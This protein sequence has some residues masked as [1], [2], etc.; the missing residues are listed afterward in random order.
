MSLAQ[1]D[2]VSATPSPLTVRAIAR[3][4]LP[5]VANAWLVT[6]AGPLLDAALGRAADPHRQ[7]AA[8]WLAFGVLM[9]A[10]SAC[11]VLPQVTAAT[12]ARGRTL[13]PVALAA[14][15]LAA[16][17]SVL[18]LA[19]A[20]TPLGTPVF[21]T[22][23]AA[24]G[25]AAALARDAL[26]PM[27]LVPPLVALRGVAAGASVRA[28]RTGALA[29]ATLV[30]VLALATLVVAVV[31]SHLRVDAIVAAWAMVFATAAEAAVVTLA[32]IA[33]RD[34]ADAARATE[35]H[36]GGHADA[37]GEEARGADAPADAARA[38]ARA[39][40]GPLA[41]ALGALARLALPLAAASLVWNATRPLVGALAGRLAEPELAQA[42]FGVVLPLLMTSC[43]PLWALLDAAIVL[44]G[45][46]ADVRR[47]A[48]YGA[49]AALA[50]AAAIALVAATPLSAL[51]LERG[52]ALSPS[53]AHVVAP[54]LVLL[55]LEPFALAARALAQGL[56]VR[57]GLA[58]VVLA[59]A[60][61][62]LAL[63]LVAGLAIARLAPHA[64]PAVFTLA[65]FVGGDALEALLY[66]VAVRRTHAHHVEHHAPGV[67]A[68][69]TVPL[70]EAA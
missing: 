61:A 38:P 69:S 18:V 65:L 30:R 40:P 17:A 58:G 3:F 47:L 39:T 51:V 16:L 67:P 25:P 5:L 12:L 44:P 70:E 55:A 7:L 26:A 36:A 45:S 57:A 66:G 37:A 11:L 52:L 60:P 20:R 23:L 9:F 54:A 4:H 2:S 43:A 33:S 13:A 19:I 62:R 42:A 53:L 14:G 46:D 31:A 27:A 1:P 59:I 29:L 63:T 22:L 28:R 34:R 32:A 10:E 64:N 56:L 15:A 21:A 41:S 49:G 68:A 48:R 24:P 35:P 8:F 6:A 50:F